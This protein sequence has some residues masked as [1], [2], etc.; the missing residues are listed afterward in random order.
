MKDR[1]LNELP[2]E[3]LI[4]ALLVSIEPRGAHATGILKV[5][6]GGEGIDLEKE[7][8]PASVF[9]HK[10]RPCLEDTK[11]ILLHTRFATQGDPSR[12]EN[13]HPVCYGTCFAVHN[14]IIQND[15][16]LFRDFEL[17]RNAE[18]DSIAI[19]AVVSKFGF[20]NIGDAFEEIDGAMATAIVDPINNPDEL[21][22]A[23]GQSNPLVVLNHKKF[24]MWASTETAIKNAWSWFIGTPPKNGYVEMWQ[25]QYLHVKDDKFEKKRFDCYAARW[26]YHGQATTYVYDHDKGAWTENRKEDRFTRQSWGEHWKWD[27]HEG[28]E[29][30][31]T[32]D[33]DSCNIPWWEK[34]HNAREQRHVYD[35]FGKGTEDTLSM[36]NV[37]EIDGQ[38]VYVEPDED[39]DDMDSFEEIARSQTGVHRRSIMG[40]AHAFGVTEA[41]VEWILCLCP[42][43]LFEE[44]PQLIDRL[45]AIRREYREQ[46]KVAKTLMNIPEDS[47][48]STEIVPYNASGEI[49]PSSHP[50]ENF[51]GL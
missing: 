2:L 8:I 10:R 14:G 40:T 30:Y 17:V 19:P 7:D 51:I 13:N 20:D 15:D 23:K 48:S 32:C 27:R 29:E 18:V 39:L 5:K 34:V 22:L 50:V 12:N 44:K 26:P 11:T 1:Y 47:P 3:N 31:A 28:I 16:D 43:E 24:I 35:D 49:D 9:I 37:I 45:K 4:N 25:G 42:A 21:I 6:K 46:V 36:D 38:L 33:D 41:F